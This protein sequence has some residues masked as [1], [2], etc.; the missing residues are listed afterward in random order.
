MENTEQKDQKIWKIA[1]KRADFKRHLYIYIVINFLLWVTWA[2]S[3]QGGHPSGIWPVYV[4]VGWGIGLL[5]S[6]FDAYH[7][8]KDS[9]AEKEYNKLKNQNQM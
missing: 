9:M 2:L 1:K 6:Y 7:Y 4:T 5:F 3:W 8:M